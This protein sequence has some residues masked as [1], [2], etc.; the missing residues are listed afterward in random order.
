MSQQTLKI[1]IKFHSLSKNH[2]L[3][4]LTKISMQKYTNIINTLNKKVFL[5]NYIISVIKFARVESTLPLGHKGG[6]ETVWARKYI[7]FTKDP[8]RRSWRKSWRKC[9]R[10]R[11]AKVLAKLRSQVRSKVR[12]QLFFNYRVTNLNH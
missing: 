10:S 9:A 2:F 8:W 7:F 11:L 1:S 5:I 6:P 3:H 12:S 4:F